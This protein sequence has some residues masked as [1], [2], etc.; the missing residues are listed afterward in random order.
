MDYLPAVEVESQ[1]GSDAN[2]SIIW[3]HGLGSNGNDFVPIVKELRLPVQLNIRFVF[4]HAPVTP[5]TV[6]NG[7]PMPAWYDIYELTLDRKVDET[8]LRA[9][10]QKTRNL[11]E[12][13]IARGVPSE[14]IIVAGFSQGGAVA[15]EA[16]LTCDKPLAGLL[17]LSTY[18]ATS[19]T[20]K[21]NTANKNISILI[22]HGTQDSVVPDVLGERAYRELSERG[23]KVN[24]EAYDMEHTLCA[25]QVD[26]ISRWM[27]VLLLS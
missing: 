12:R 25:E 6:N 14:K 26:S 5:V 20:I 4:P 1:P 22:Q 27:Q 21:A 10:A 9:S 3:L 19:G 24:Y 17:T 8:Q 18:F 13:E 23:Y 16:A 2:A 15:Y 11:I 7:Y